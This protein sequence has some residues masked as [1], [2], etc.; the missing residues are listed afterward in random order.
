[1]DGPQKVRAQRGL[2]AGEL[3]A[4]LAPRLHRDRIVQDLLDVL[5]LELVHE[6]DLVGIHEAR[7]AHHVAAVREVD[8]EDRAP[9]VLDRRGAVLAQLRPGRLEVAPREEPL[10]AREERRVDA[11]D[12]LERAMLSA[13]LPHHDAPSVLHDLRADLARVAA[14]QRRDVALAGE[15]RGT[16]RLYALGAQR[17]RLPGPTELGKGALLLAEQGS[18]GP[19]GGEAGPGE[20]LGVRGDERPGG[21]SGAPERV[22]RLDPDPGKQVVHGARSIPERHLLTRRE[23]LPAAG[24]LNYRPETRR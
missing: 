20:T 1:F 19:R 4:E 2:S 16:H 13:G 7:V 10:D 22:F 11:E 21:T 24:P 8:R 14:E 9:P 15:H 23:G 6:A 17:V 12:V 5:P 3:H 18:G